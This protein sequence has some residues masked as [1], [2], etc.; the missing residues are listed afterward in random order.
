MYSM[1][2]TSCIKLEFEFG[3]FDV[4][5]ADGVMYFPP[6]VIYPTSESPN[7]YKLIPTLMFFLSLAY[8]HFRDYAL[9]GVMLL[10]C[11]L[12]PSY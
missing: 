2:S 1:I 10:S 7:V 4:C 3:R 11:D 9:R 8:A 12:L 6:P 5:I